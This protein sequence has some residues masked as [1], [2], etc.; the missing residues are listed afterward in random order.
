VAR[1]LQELNEGHVQRVWLRVGA[2]P[3]TAEYLSW[4][5]VFVWFLF[6]FFCFFGFWIFG[7]S[8]QGF[9]V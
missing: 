3:A 1:R 7:F 6:L 9:S 4:L 5:P 8:R 2:P